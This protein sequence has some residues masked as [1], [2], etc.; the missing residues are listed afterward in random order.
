MESRF[1]SIEQLLADKSE[2]A[3]TKRKTYSQALLLQSRFSE[4]TSCLESNEILKLY[5]KVIS[6][7]P[8]WEDGHFYI[9]KYYDKI[10]TTLLED[11]HD[12]VPSPP[13]LLAMVSI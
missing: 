2:N 13:P 4:E 8:D 6:V 5:R 11:K 1:G 9:G 7:N 3:K 10:I 12:K